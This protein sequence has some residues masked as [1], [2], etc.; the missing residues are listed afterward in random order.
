MNESRARA[1]RSPH[2]PPVSARSCVL[3][4]EMYMTFYLQGINNVMIYFL[5]MFTNHFQWFS[6]TG[7]VTEHSGDLARQQPFC[8]LH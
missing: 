6:T 7:G 2:T 8:A 1:L 4:V 3:P 5:L